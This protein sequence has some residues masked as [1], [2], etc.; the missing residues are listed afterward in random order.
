MLISVFSY[1]WRVPFKNIY[2]LAKKPHFVVC[3]CKSGLRR[4]T[5]LY[6]MSCHGNFVHHRITIINHFYHWRLWYFSWF[7]KKL[8]YFSNFSISELY[9]FIYV[10]CLEHWCQGSNLPLAFS[11]AVHLFSRVHWTKQV[12]ASKLP[13]I[14]CATI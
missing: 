3:I 13:H 8:S 11:S 6:N 5:I 14:V 7:L 10:N 4:I 2:I 9:L 1:N 12:Y